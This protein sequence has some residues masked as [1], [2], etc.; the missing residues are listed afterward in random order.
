MI[1]QNNGIAICFDLYTHGRTQ[2]LSNKATP[3]NL[4]LFLSQVHDIV[5]SPDL[6]L[7][8]HSRFHMLGFSFGGWITL[9]YLLK[10]H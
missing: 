2:I 7:S 5:H 3:H 1:A 8:R 10:Y 9:N 4:D 6:F